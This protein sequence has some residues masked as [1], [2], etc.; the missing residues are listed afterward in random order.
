MRPYRAVQ[1]VWFSLGP[2]AFCAALYGDKEGFNWSTSL[3][4]G[5]G[6]REY[7]GRLQ[8]VIDTLLVKRAFTVNATQFNARI[9]DQSVFAAKH[10]PGGCTLY[11]S[12]LPAEGVSLLPGDA[13][14]QSPA[15]CYTIVMGRYNSFDSRVVR[16]VKAHMGR[17]SLIRPRGSHRKHESVCH[18]MLDHL[19]VCT[20]NEVEGVWVK[21]LWGI[22]KE[23]FP[24][25]MHQDHP[26]ADTNRW[27]WWYVRKHGWD[28]GSQNVNDVA[29]LDLAMIAKA[30]LME[31]GVPEHQID[32]RDAYLPPGTYWDGRK[33]APRNLVV[34]KCI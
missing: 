6:R 3:L 9:L 2:H 5:I 24:H 31:R 13:A 34:V 19:D 14:L 15:G 32:L 10:Y 28:K 17:W 25:P 21:I 26:H 23:H 11:Q 1:Q 7:C 12:S 8:S 16:P 30:Q 22:R 27:L 33:G 4:A 20:R 29:Y 18:A